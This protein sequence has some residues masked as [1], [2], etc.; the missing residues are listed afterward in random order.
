MI[1]YVIVLIFSLLFLLIA[2][3]IILKTGWLII[4][5]YTIV[6]M[7]QYN[8]RFDDYDFE[9]KQIDET[10]SKRESIKEFEYYL[11]IDKSYNEVYNMIVG[12]RDRIIYSAYACNV[13][14]KIRG[15]ETVASLFNSASNRGVD[16]TIFYNTSE[17]YDNL[18]IADLLE[19]LDDSIHVITIE[20]TEN[21][22]KLIQNMSKQKSYSFNHMKFLIADEYVLFGGCD[23]DPNERLGYGVVNKSKYSWHEVSF[24]FK[25][26]QSF[27]D[28]IDVFKKNNKKFKICNIEPPPLPFLQNKQELNILCSMIKNSVDVLYIEHQLFAISLYSESSQLLIHTFTDRIS[29]SLNNNDNLKIN[30]LTNISQDDEQSPFTQLFSASTVMTGFN[31]LIN[32]INKKTGFSRK[33]I[34]DKINLLTLV[35]KNNYKI[36]VHSNL[37]I[38]DDRDGEYHCIR[39][40]SNLSDRSY[41]NNTCDIELGVYLTGTKVK[42]LLEELIK[43]H[44]NT[45]NEYLIPIANVHKIDIKSSLFYEFFTLLSTTHPAS[46]NCNHLMKLKHER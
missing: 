26:S 29:R 34:I 16:I 20:A 21:I 43:L 36:K 42:T 7:C 25:V 1:I 37:I 19:I 6:K 2:Q 5:I 18:K 12:A 40:S 33:H 3:S 8:Q 23:I 15:N 28:W 31:Q 30:I 39:T 35:D 17:E 45:Y 41:G 46:G 24:R 38:T 9:I 22:N 44:I 13:Y 10:L 32:L 11:T 14:T 27:I 4:A